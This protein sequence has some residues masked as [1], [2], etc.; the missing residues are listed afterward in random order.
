MTRAVALLSLFFLTSTIACSGQPGTSDDDPGG[1]DEGALALGGGED[2][3][4]TIEPG[5]YDTATHDLLMFVKKDGGKVTISFAL[6]AMHGEG[7]AKKAGLMGGSL[8]AV[9]DPRVQTELKLERVGPHAFHVTGKASSMIYGAPRVDVDAMVS[10]RTDLYEG[11]YPVAGKVAGTE[12]RVTIKH[13]D[14]VGLT[15]SVADN[16]ATVYDGVVPWASAQDTA[17][18][19]V[20]GC[21]GTLS[22]LATATRTVDLMFLSSCQ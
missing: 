11:S 19:T 22:V 8:L 18:F 9:E 16:G 14:Q 4:S 12:R 3:L 13:S 6:Q 2:L 20:S 21:R 1:G 10:F 5:H 7:V 15:L 17:P